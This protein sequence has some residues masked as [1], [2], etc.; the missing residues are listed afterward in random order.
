MFNFRLSIIKLMVAIVTLYRQML[1][2]VRLRA[3]GD[4]MKLAETMIGKSNLKA[5]RIC[6][7]RNLLEVHIL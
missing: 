3:H 4:L 6:V 5:P 2:G 1:T 7:L